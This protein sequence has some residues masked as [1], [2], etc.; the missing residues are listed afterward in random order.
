MPNQRKFKL[1]TVTIACIT[2]ILI[3][4]TVTLS[5]VSINSIKY[6]G[7]HAIEIDKLS[8]RENAMVFFLEITRRTAGAYSTY[9]NAVEDF[10]EILADQTKE[11]LTRNI[12]NMQNKKKPVKL[13]KYNNFDI[14]TL[15]DKQNYNCFYFGTSTN[16]KKAENQAKNLI[17]LSPLLKTI[18]EENSVYFVNIWIQTNSKIY[19]E[20]PKYYKYEQ[21]NGNS[22]KKYFNNIYS[23][24]IASKINIP[25]KVIW[26]KPYKDIS[27]KINLDAYKLMYTDDGKFL[28][29]VGVDINFKK[30]LKVITKNNLFSNKKSR[31]S[32]DIKSSYNKMKGFIFI[33]D[34]DGTIIAFPN[35]YS[36]IISLPD[37]EYSKLKEY[38]DKLTINLKDSL[39]IDIRNMAKEIESSKIGVQNFS[40]NGENYIIAHKSIPPTGW[41]LC[42]ATLEKSLMTSTE[43]TKQT[44]SSTENKMAIR[45]II[46]SVFFLLLFIAIAIFFFRFYLL[47]PLFNIRRKV[48]EIGEGNFDISLSETGFAE[49]SDLSITFNNLTQEL[50][51]YTRNLENEV[52]QRQSIETELEIAGKLQNSVL[53]KITDEFINNKF[54]IYAKL[55]SAKEMSGDFYDFFYINSDTLCIVLADVSGKGIT[56]AFYM[57]MAKA[58]IKEACLTTNPIDTGIVMQK[59]NHTLCGSVKT[60]MFLTMYLVYYNINTGKVTYTNAGHHEYIRTNNKGNVVFSGESHNTFAGFFDN[61]EYTN[62]EFLLNPGET[63]IL[64]TDG[65][66]DACNNDNITYGTERLKKVIELNH[67]QQLSALGHSIFKDVT[68]FQPKSKFDDITLVMLRREN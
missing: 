52:K 10:V 1:S 22:M 3:G 48:K 31:I 28:A 25:P 15:Q 6:L 21:I 41:I 42:F 2:I 4:L 24:Y 57:S 64:Y 54:N 9:F 35:K 40:I 12:K 66:F 20:Y 63:F 62:S 50:K 47:K 13:K 49:I 46:I 65:I 45:F 61:I 19:F 34:K 43:K 37:I 23:E 58:I 8:T 11:V 68:Q 16:I 59:I 38:P 32:D 29:T 51:D 33:V 56:A 36:S 55:V 53:P 5:Y 67:S 26:A 17:T 44:I 39:N 14:Y 60:P 18:Y 7:N 27:G 30:F